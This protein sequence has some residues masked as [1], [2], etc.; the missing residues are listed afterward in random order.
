MTK[1]A[2][3]LFAKGVMFQFNA[4]SIAKNLITLFKIIKYISNVFHDLQ[5]IAVG[6]NI[7]VFCKYYLDIKFNFDLI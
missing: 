3:H 4:L 1:S 6:I 2:Y 7:E 5:E